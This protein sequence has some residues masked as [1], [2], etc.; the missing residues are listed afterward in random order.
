MGSRYQDPH[1]GIMRGI[2]STPS[3]TTGRWDRSAARAVYKAT[4]PKLNAWAV[5]YHV[6]ATTTGGKKLIWPASAP[7]I[8]QTVVRTL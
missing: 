8:N 5:E 1:D 3:D 6:R 4:L 7:E 2:R